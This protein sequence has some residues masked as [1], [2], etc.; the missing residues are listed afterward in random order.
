[1]EATKTSSQQQMF[2][3]DIPLHTQDPIQ[4]P[5][6]QLKVSSTLWQNMRIYLL[7]RKRAKA[8]FLS[9]CNTRNSWCP[10]YHTPTYNHITC[11]N[12]PSH[13]K[14]ACYDK[15]ILGN[16][17]RRIS[18]T[19]AQILTISNFLL[20]LNRSH[21]CRMWTQPNI[22]RTITLQ[23]T[24]SQ[25]RT[26]IWKQFSPNYRFCRRAVENDTIFFDKTEKNVMQSYIRYKM[27]YDKKT[28]A[29]RL[30]EKD[31]CYILQPKADHQG[32]KIPFRE[33]RLIGPYVRENVLPN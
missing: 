28:Q 9:A 10:R 31:Y 7:Y 24:R 6:T 12:H 27:Y 29:S 18:Q 25:A 11:K 13:R 5:S 3:P 2:F 14:N 22:S 1:M 16:V 33:F 21:E 23:H 17:F 32:S 30:P 8:Q 4:Q 19:L 26:F 15:D 20:Q